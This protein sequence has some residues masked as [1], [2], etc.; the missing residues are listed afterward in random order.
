[1]KR[2]LATLIT[3]CLICGMFASCGLF[4]SENG[5]TGISG[6]P[7]QLS[8]VMA[9]NNGSLADENGDYP[10]WIELYNASDSDFNL[11]GYSLT[12]KVE[13]RDKFIFPSFTIKAGEYLVIYADGKNTVDTANRI[14]HLPYSINATAED[15]LLYNS[16]GELLGQIAITNA[17]T[18]V[19]YGMEGQFKS[20][21]PGAAN[22]EIVTAEDNS[23]GNTNNTQQSDLPIY[24]NEYATKDSI[25]YADDTGEFRAWVELYNYGTE[26]IDLTGY[27]L[28]DDMEEPDKWIFPGGTIPAGG[29]LVIF[30]SGMER[31][32]NEG[33]P[34]HATFS[35]S[36]KEEALSLYTPS[37]AMIDTIPVY[38]LT[39]NLTYGRPELEPTAGKFFPKAT[40]GAA[41]TIAGFDQIESAKYPQNKE[42]VISEIAAVN[43][44]YP[45]KV[46]SKKQPAPRDDYIELYNPSDEPVSLEGYWLFK[47]SVENM[48]VLPNITIQPNSYYILFCGTEENPIGLNRYG[49]E[50]YLTDPEGVVIDSVETGRMS[51]GTSNGR[52]S[53]TDDTVY[54]F[55]TQTAGKANPTTGLAGP[56]PAPSFSKESGYATAGEQITISCPGA[57]IRYTTDGSTPTE[58]SLVY[59]GQPI[60]LTET[61]TIRARA[62]MD[63]RMPS[64]DTAGSYI[65]GR[66]HNMPVIFLSSD[67]D[68]LF[69]Y[70]NGILANGP[71]YT[72]TQ[73]HET[74]ANYSQDWERAAH[75]QYIDEN[76]VAQLEF[77]AGIKVFGQYS[78]DLA[79][80]SLSINLRDKYGPK[81]ICYP[82]FAGNHTN[83]FSELVLRNSGQDNGVAHLRDA[84]CAM[85]VKGQMDLDIM[86]YRPVVVYLN[87]EYYGLY[88]LR[89]KIC[90]DY[91]ANHH[92]TDPENI[93]MIKGNSAIMSGDLTAWKELLSYVNSHDLSVQANY[94][95]VASQV[96]IE[97]LCNWWIVESFFN[98]TD[99]GNIKFYRERTDGAKW[100]W[101]LFDLDWALYPSTYKWNMVEEM[102]NPSGHGVGK[103]FDTD[104]MVALVANQ[105]FREYFISTYG[106][107][108]RTVF[109]TERMLSIFDAMVA[110]IEAEM[111]YQIERWGAPSSYSRWESNVKRL[112]EIVAEKNALVRA[113]VIDT[114]TNSTVSY[115]RQFSMSKAEVIALLD[116]E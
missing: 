47:N 27:S 94:D 50:L 107:Y 103:M 70:S 102:F 95:Y 25:T 69:S 43:T 19:S 51:E 65:I 91:V 55:N 38:D 79:Q 54:Y 89:E 88:D 13:K 48:Y 31:E 18:N 44:T 99:T 5:G 109:D 16:M 87:G 60:T 90:E 86:D 57:V 62:Y 108:L 61:I 97:E 98:N 4:D 116:G 21:T 45:E 67:P 101:V 3:I 56:A 22:S 8:E 28:S 80:K 17:Q 82:F 6:S 53:M 2:L 74:G 85:V 7:V 39:A 105:G 26:V 14:I 34:I 33:E 63:G 1:M 12:D 71:G 35:L 115:M 96:D 46:S 75:V 111:P 93:D 78:R 11:E 20:P 15:V 110:E 106:K 24:I 114:F 10:D 23:E 73:T 29:Y 92:G 113:D 9:S 41:N 32:Y 112:R 72:G 52:V 40:P 59:D 83:V 76:G 42:V 64:D 77:N 104:L 100:R 30:L 81:E 68:G 66:T 58:N 36:G 84:F 37:G 49:Q